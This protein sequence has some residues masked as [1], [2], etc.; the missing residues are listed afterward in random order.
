MR[1]QN[2]IKLRR[3]IFPVDYIDKP[4]SKEVLSELLDCAN[5]APTH[6]L[7]QPWRYI[8]FYEDGLGRLAKILQEAYKKETS[9]DQYKEKKFRSIS[10]KVLKSG[11]VMAICLHLSGK[12][13]EEEELAAV[14]CSV[15]NMWLAAYELGI[16]AYWSTPAY[17]GLTTKKLGLK[18]NERCIGLFYMG[19]HDA[20]PRTGNRSPMEGKTTWIAG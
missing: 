6:K 17:L 9:I 15:Q 16:G 13:P 2:I 5:A 19:Y 10:E 1:I 3:S 14:A 18:D 11:A 12:I 4:I 8:V 20:M 7:T